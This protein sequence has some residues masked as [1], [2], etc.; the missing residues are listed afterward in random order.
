MKADS[1]TNN[2]NPNATD[3]TE[4][5]LDVSKINGFIVSE[6][7]TLPSQAMYID[8][9]A[10]DTNYADFKFDVSTLDIYLGH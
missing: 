10:V 9:N 7:Q 4:I 8:R 5:S 1:G 2:N 3:Q 6:I